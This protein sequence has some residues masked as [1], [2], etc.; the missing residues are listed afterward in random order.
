MDSPM[1]LALCSEGQ[2]VGRKV[3]G[4]GRKVRIT[5][6]DM[7]ER[8][9]SFPQGGLSF[10]A[11]H[12]ALLDFKNRVIEFGTLDVAKTVNLYDVGRINPGVAAVSWVKYLYERIRM[13]SMIIEEEQYDRYE[14]PPDDNAYTLLVVNS[15][16]AKDDKLPVLRID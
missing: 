1:Y 3:A 9:I 10:T 5:P 16:E 2:K 13:L 6:E 12:W 4:L 11:S 7:Y 15:K 8:S 14:P